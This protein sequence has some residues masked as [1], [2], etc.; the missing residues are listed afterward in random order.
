MKLSFDRL[1]V[2]SIGKSNRRAFTLTETLA[3]LFILGLIV[4]FT[5]PNV[6]RS[7]Y[8]EKETHENT[9][10][11][12]Y[13][14]SV[15]ARMKGNLLEDREIT[16]GVEKAELFDYDYKVEEINGFRKLTVG[17]LDHENKR[18]ELEVFLKKERIYAD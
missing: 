11:L 2:I 7:L 5:L 6:N 8:L 9:Q 16:T 10:Q 12:L 13:L 14:K 17:V 15:M 18:M 3:G 1:P 4:I